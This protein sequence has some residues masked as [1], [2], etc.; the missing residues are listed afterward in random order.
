K[1]FE[2]SPTLKDEE[3]RPPMLNCPGFVRNLDVLYNN[4]RA[5][6]KH[7]RE[8]SV[9]CENVS[10]SGYAL[11]DY[12]C[13][14]NSAAVVF[15]TLPVYAV[16]NLAGFYECD[17]CG[18]KMFP[19]LTPCCPK[20]V[21]VENQRPWTASDIPSFEEFRAALADGSFS[22]VNAY[23][24]FAVFACSFLFAEWI[25]TL[26]YSEISVKA[27]VDEEWQY[28]F[29]QFIERGVFDE[30]FKPVQK[31][32]HY[33]GIYNAPE[34]SS[35]LLSCME[36]IDHLSSFGSSL[37]T[38]RNYKKILWALV[39]IFSYREYFGIDKSIEFAFWEPS[40]FSG[41]K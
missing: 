5:L 31:A 38:M 1:L 27:F 9:V 29:S 40:D 34:V 24:L 3:D 37:Q 17:T 26:E 39:D 25:Q 30:Y 23:G 18:S 7:L 10:S 33:Y 14:F 35:H 4:K 21:P 20:Y 6:F 2:F 13:Y 8:Q 19:I 11:H 22:E 41:T 15:A 12:S 32:N 36:L 28:L 16:M